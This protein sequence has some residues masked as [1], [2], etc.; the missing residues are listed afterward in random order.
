MSRRKKIRSETC[1]GSFRD[2]LDPRNEV[3]VLARNRTIVLRVIGK[4]NLE[5]EFASLLDVPQH[6]RGKVGTLLVGT[7]HVRNERKRVSFQPTLH[8]I[9]SVV[10]EA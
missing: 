2:P 7:L 10:P 1:Y 6:L 5:R 3:I 4:R 9:N 8:Y